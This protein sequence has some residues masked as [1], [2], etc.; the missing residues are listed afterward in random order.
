M[1]ASEFAEASAHF[2]RAILL[3]GDEK[4]S[5]KHDTS[6]VLLQDAAEVSYCIGDFNRMDRHLDL[7]L[8]NAKTI[9]DRLRAYTI[10]IY[11]SGARHRVREALDTAM[12]ILRQLG[13]P[14]PT[15]IGKITFVAEMIK[16][17]WNLLG[18]SQRF[19]TVLRCRRPQT[20]LT[21]LP[22]CRFCS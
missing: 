21:R 9:E 20:T 5:D 22:L 11:A 2:E 8:Q 7:V 12:D 10:Q 1:K 18:K 3:L 6:I 16:T 14:L 19:F 15:K 17:K 13:E 4:W